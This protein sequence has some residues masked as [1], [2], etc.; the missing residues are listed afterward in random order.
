MIS[1]A[2]T[3]AN[4]GLALMTDEKKQASMAYSIHSVEPKRRELEEMKTTLIEQ[5]EEKRHHFQLLKLYI[6]KLESVRRRR[7][8]DRFVVTRC[9]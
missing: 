3:L 6:D 8:T 4:D 1:Q 9:F 2:N 7:P 5:I